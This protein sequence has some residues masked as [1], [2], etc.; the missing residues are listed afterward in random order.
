MLN[1]STDSWV[2]GNAQEVSNSLRGL[3]APATKKILEST[4]LLSMRSHQILLLT[5]RI[6]AAV[7]K[8]RR[9]PRFSGMSFLFFHADK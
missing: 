6:Y 5:L 8:S 2:K 4:L 9:L 1:S 3:L 7:A